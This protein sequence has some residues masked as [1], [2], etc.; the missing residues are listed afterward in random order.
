MR[1]GDNNRQKEEFSRGWAEEN[2]DVGDHSD[3]QNDVV[4]V[5]SVD[6]GSLIVTDG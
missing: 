2:D 6:V 4:E 5:D 1:C 3:Q